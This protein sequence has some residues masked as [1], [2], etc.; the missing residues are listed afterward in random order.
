MTERYNR[1]VRD[2]PLDYIQPIEGAARAKYALNPIAGLP[3]DQFF[4]RGGLTFAAVNGE[5]RELYNTP[6]DN[7]MP[8]LGFA[9]QLTEDGKT[10]IRGGYG[11][12][13]GFL[14]QRRGDVNQTGFSQNTPF[15][16]VGSNG[17]SIVNTLSNPFPDGV[18]EPVGAG[19]G[20]Q[21]N[22]GNAVTFFNPNPEIGK[23]QRWQFSIQRELPWGFVVEA[24]YVGNK[25]SDIEV[26]R[27]LNATPLKYLSTSPLRDATVENFLGGNVPNPLR[28]LVPTNSTIGSGTNIIRERLL[29]PYPHF[30]TVNTTTNE[31]QSWYHSGQLNVQK[32]FSQG[33]T[34]NLAYT[35]S[36]FIE[37]IDLLN[38]SDPAPTKMISAF[39]APHRVALSWIYE[40]PFGKGKAIGDSSN[41]VISRVLTGWQVTGIYAWQVGPPLNFATNVIYLGGKIALP[42]DQRSLNRWFDTSRFDTRATALING[43]STQIQPTGRNIRTF[44]LRF[45]DVRAENVN[46]VDVSLFKNTAITEGTKFQIRF[47]LLN[48]LNHPWLFSG[49][50]IQ[51]NPTASNFG[52]I[53]A[54]NQANYARRVQVMLKF[55]F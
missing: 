28:D 44:P 32:R 23:M 12:Y 14:G 20:F 47:D 53:T 54:G 6:R 31:G 37:Q 24:A 13:Y 9:Y 34:V 26:N 10:V 46:N 15:I 41:P 19:L 48:A 50:A 30:D 45:S 51:M 7:F 21:T 39:D 29:R 11:E 42:E 3:A 17:F 33:Y 25:G 40:L 2:F 38:A 1:S 4:V 27:N 52:Q 5:P 35:W 18:Q 22:I 16:T 49:G 55:I 8:R 36:K 43:V